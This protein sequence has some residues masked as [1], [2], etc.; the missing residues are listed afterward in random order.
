MKVRITFKTSPSIWG[1]TTATHRVAAPKHKMKIANG[2][3]GTVSLLSF[4]YLKC[5]KDIGGIGLGHSA[6][7]IKIVARRRKHYEV[8]AGQ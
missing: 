4:G 2:D 8:A 6:M 5:N 7:A 1:V 3:S